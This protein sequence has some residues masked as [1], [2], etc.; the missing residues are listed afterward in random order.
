[1]AIEVKENLTKEEQEILDQTL[2]SFFIRT[3]LT[4]EEK[5]VMNKAID[6]VIQDKYPNLKS[7]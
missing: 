6:L 2:D 1:M 7:S 4:S 5:R 3:S